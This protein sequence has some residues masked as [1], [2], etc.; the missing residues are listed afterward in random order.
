M[1]QTL[2]Y[3][4]APCYFYLTLIYSIYKVSVIASPNFMALITVAKFCET[5]LIIFDR[6]RE[7]RTLTGSPNTA[8]P[9]TL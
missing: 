2:S 6:E 4:H 1:I 3:Q 8:Y 5:D 7:V 9:T